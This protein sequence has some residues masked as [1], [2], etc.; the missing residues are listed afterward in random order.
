MKVVRNIFFGLVIAGVMVFALGLSFAETETTT[1]VPAET[2]VVASEA[3][4][5]TAPAETPVVASEAT[6][7]TA[8][9]ETPVL[10]P[11]ATPAETKA[12]A[13]LAA[14]AV[15]ND[16]L[17]EHKPRTD[18]FGNILR[19]SAAALQATNPDLAMKLT[20]IVIGISKFRADSNIKKVNP[21]T[22]NFWQSVMQEFSFI[23]TQ[24]QLFRRPIQP[25]QRA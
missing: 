21:S 14:Q 4:P 5:A 22:L 18:P 25:W 16:F 23:K 24:Q 6:P 9:A 19:D 13:P 20:D 10:A 2:P 17:A 1:A 8:P 3:T 7:A 12:V 15:A 11:E